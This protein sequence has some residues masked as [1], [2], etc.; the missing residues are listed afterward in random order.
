MADGLL[1]AVRLALYADLGL[2]FGM[3]LFALYA[4]RREQ[5]G[6][7]PV[8]TL[9]AV[10]AVGG[11][12]FSL[13]GFALLVAAMSGTTL[14]ELDPAMV[15][16]LMTQTAVGWAFLGR[17]AALMLILALSL[18]RPRLW[19]LAL[20]GGIAV[21]TLAWSGHGASSEGAAGVAHLGA[22][23]A[24]LLAAS[25]WIGALA[26][27]LMLVSPQHDVSRDRL[28]AAHAALA[29]FG[30]AGTLFVGIIV[31][32][33]LVNGLFVVGADKLLL[34]GR[35]LYGQLLL[36]KLLLFGAMLAC[37][38]LNRFRLT[39]R[40]ADAIAQGATAQALAGL[41]RSLAVEA[42][43][44][45]LILGLVGWLGTLEPPMTGV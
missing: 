17:V 10:L 21:A 39:P 12:A 11:I 28:E 40:L 36:A 5:R 30:T 37:A 45:I 18:I 41:R 27:F 6:L 43:L 26:M 3:P 2:L 7:L 19:L 1:V 38:A 29:G 15:R 25:A 8:A 9:S 42:G 32:T 44:A 20:S 16:M 33:G 31:A 4:L 22:D 23:I 35:S 13:L 34:L 14:R 24:H